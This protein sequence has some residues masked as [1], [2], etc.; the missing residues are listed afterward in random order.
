MQVGLNMQLELTEGVYVC[1]QN[2]DVLNGPVHTD[3]IYR[4]KFNMKINIPA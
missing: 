2:W 1:V 4:A 3:F